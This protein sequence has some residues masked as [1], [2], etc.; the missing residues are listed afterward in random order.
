MGGIGIILGIFIPALVM[1]ATGMKTIITLWSPVLVFAISAAIGVIFGF[2][3]AR[4]AAEL[5][6][7]TALRNE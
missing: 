6:S 1:R 4:S 2:Y 3:P 7:I 5:D